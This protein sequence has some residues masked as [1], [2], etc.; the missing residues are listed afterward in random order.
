MKIITS[1][2]NRKGPPWNQKRVE[3]GGGPEI[4]PTK[5]G[6]KVSGFKKNLLN[7][8]FTSNSANYG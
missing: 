2:T 6:L 7:N 5:G 4:A 3:G 1:G 8:F